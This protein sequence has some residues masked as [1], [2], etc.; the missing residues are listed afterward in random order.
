MSRKQFLSLLVAAVLFLAGCG[1]RLTSNP[2]IPSPLSGKKIAVPIFVN[3]SY[4][5]NVGGIVADSVV[6]EFAR[7]TGG[8][9]VREDAADLILSGTVLT[10]TNTPVSY[11]ANDNVKEYRMLA[12]VEATL[13]EKSTRK[14]LWKGT[15]AW[16]QNYPAF[17]V[18]Q[19]VVVFQTVTSAVQQTFNALQQNS[20]EAAIREVGAR[21]AEQLYERVAAGF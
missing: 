11:D 4:R 12:T 9:V 6:D 17:V 14:V 7:R 10:C 13:M 21:L 1:Y 15:L 20:E 8:R 5:A 18:Q 2:N 19:N 16:G 3:K